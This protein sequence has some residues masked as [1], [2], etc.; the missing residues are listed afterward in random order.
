MTEC[1]CLLGTVLQAPSSRVGLFVPEP[2]HR[3]GYSFEKHAPSDQ[4]REYKVIA[5]A[6]HF[7]TQTF[8]VKNPLTPRGPTSPGMGKLASMHAHA[9]M[10]THAPPT[11][12]SHIHT[13][14]H[15][16]TRYI[17]M[18]TNTYSIFPSLCLYF[19][20]TDADRSNHVWLPTPLV[21]ILGFD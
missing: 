19:L 18:Q 21:S 8:V 17:E 12:P 20:A 4:F 11:A 13:D 2:Y 3:G 7:S 6:H 10:H 1:F 9:C 14:T 5:V 16:H 15:T